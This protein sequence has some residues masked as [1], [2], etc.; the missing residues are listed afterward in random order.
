MS[1]M[2]FSRQWKRWTCFPHLIEREC[3]ASNGRDNSSMPDDKPRFP[4]RRFDV[5]A[6]Y[7]R[8]TNERHGM[9]EDLAK[10]RAIWAAK[11]VA[12]R[13]YGAAPP[14]RSSSSSQGNK[15]SDKHEHEEDGGFRSVGGALQTDE[16]FDRE[17]VSRM[18]SDF[19]ERIFRPAIEQA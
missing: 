18:G 15:A 2:P 17:I 11:V 12:G 16:T 7:H 10:G 1:S 3:Q 5:F 19:Y 14:P 9:P 4:I 13:R 8:I 6:E